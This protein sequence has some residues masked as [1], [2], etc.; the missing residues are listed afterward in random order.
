M[1]EGLRRKSEDSGVGERSKS[2]TE[3][4]DTNG[5]RLQIGKVEDVGKRAAGN[6]FKI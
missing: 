6:L 2:G 4:I 3:Q 1:M 5:V